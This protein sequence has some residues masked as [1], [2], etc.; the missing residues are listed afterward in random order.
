MKRI[1]FP[2]YFLTAVLLS[3]TAACR[4]DAATII[5]RNTLDDG[6]GAHA[7]ATAAFVPFDNTDSNPLNNGGGMLGKMTIS[8]AA[9]LAFWNAGN[10][11][12]IQAAFQPFG[13]GFT[14]ESTGLA[15]AFLD[16]RTADTRASQ[17][18]LGGSPV[19]FWAFKG[20]TIGAA[21]EHLIAHLAAT[22][23]TDPESGPTLTANANLRPGEIA[24]LV[25]GG[26]G[27]FS[28]DYGG[29]SG[30]L[31]GFNTVAQVPEPAGHWLLLGG[32]WLVGLARLSR[33]PRAIADWRNVSVN[34]T[35]S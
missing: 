1:P 25:V 27:N 2:T 24:N 31:P 16:S 20:P 32:A 22:F 35:A 14:L 34:S 33:R 3:A 5:F 19:Y 6:T 7:L 9:I 17:N 8:D 30:T 4:G 18:S 10:I 12:A 15:G 28:F 26:S 11:A 29:G 21:T 23:P 13:T